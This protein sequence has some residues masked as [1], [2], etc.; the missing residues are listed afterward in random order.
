MWANIII[1]TQNISRNECD[2]DWHLDV[3]SAVLTEIQKGEIDVKAEFL[4]TH[5]SILH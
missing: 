5:K 4:K 3:R 1:E 2:T